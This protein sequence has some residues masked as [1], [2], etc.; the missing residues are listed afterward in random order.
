MTL[1]PVGNGVRATLSVC[2]I[3]SASGPF[4]TAALAPL[5]DIAMEI[6]IAAGGPVDETDLSCY[7]E[8]ADRVYS[9]EFEFVERHLA[10]LHA[11]CSGDWILRLDGDEIPSPEMIAEV[12]LALEDRQVNAVYFA[13]RTLCPTIERYIAQEPW[14]PDFQLRMVRNDGAMRFSGLVHSSAERTLPAR[15]LETPIYHLPM[16]LAGPQERRARAERYERFRPG[17][18]AP[19]GLPV[20]DALLPEAIPGL[21]TAPVPHD[22][23]ELIEAV[24]AAS[25]PAR[26]PGA[27]VSVPLHETDTLWAS[28]AFADSAHRASITVIGA[29]LPFRPDERRPI[30]FKVRNEGTELWGWDPSIGPYLHVVHRLLDGDGVPTDDWRPSFFTEWVRPGAETIVPG[31]LDAPAAPGRYTLQVRVRHAPE[32]LFGTAPDTEIVVRVGGA[33]LADHPAR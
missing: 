27:V 1:A 31:H 12:L 29:P 17:L 9:I 19:A 14:Y 4:I 30:Y 16:I 8:V 22:D 3:T 20:N 25:T 26:A 10:W 6:V 21:L 18:I 24:L 11:Q 33:W 5:R 23:V 13:R 7:R 32:V 2:C 28:R 15:L